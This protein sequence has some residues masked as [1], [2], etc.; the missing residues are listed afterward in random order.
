MLFGDLR[1]FPVI[2]RLLPPSISR[3]LSSLA[4]LKSSPLPSP[5]CSWPTPFYF[6]S[7]WIWSPESLLP[8]L[9]CNSNHSALWCTDCVQEGGVSLL[10]GALTPLGG[11]KVGNKQ[12]QD[13]SGEPCEQK[14]AMVLV[15][16][17]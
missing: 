2:V 7:V 5:P 13:G 3:I 16:L 10:K 6:M 8:D 12:K 11:D 4:P 17:R 9:Q 1:Y 14:G 15:L